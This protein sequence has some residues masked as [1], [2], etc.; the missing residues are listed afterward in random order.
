MHNSINFAKEQT[1]A[2]TNAAIEKFLA[3]G[4]EIQRLPTGKGT[5][6]AKQMRERVRGS[7]PTKDQIENALIEQ[8]NVTTDHM[9]REIV[10]N[11]LGERIA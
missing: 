3:N 10:T 1:R 5:M 6:T 11:G 9:G 7:F 4:G 2:Q 8:R